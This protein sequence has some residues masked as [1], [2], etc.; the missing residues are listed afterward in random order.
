MGE[1]IKGCIFFGRCQG[2]RSSLMACFCRLCNLSK[3][4]ILPLVL[5]DVALICLAQLK[6]AGLMMTSRRAVESASMV[7]V[8]GV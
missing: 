3:P 2:V 1:L 8:E 6:E 4:V 7:N 5:V